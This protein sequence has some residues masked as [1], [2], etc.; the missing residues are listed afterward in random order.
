MKKDRQY[1]E[2]FSDTNGSSALPAMYLEEKERRKDIE[3]RYN[4]L[5]NLLKEEGCSR[6]SQRIR[7][8]L[9]AQKR[10]H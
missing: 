3:R 8:E 6:V 1:E 9:E 4:V 10:L 7:D 5:V 2:L